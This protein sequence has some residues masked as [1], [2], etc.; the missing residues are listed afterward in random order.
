MGEVA[1]RGAAWL[2]G[3]TVVS[4]VVALVG[5]VILARLLTDDEFGLYALALTIP[6]VT[7]IIAQPGIKQVLV[8][9]QRRADL[10]ENPG[11]WMSA[12]AGMAGA[13]LTAVAAPLSAWLYGGGMMMVKVVLVIAATIFVSALATVPEARM[14]MG[15]RFKAAAILNWATVTGAMALSAAMAWGGWGALSFAVPNL[16][17]A[18]V[19]CGAM[20]WMTR[21][22]IGMTLQVRRWWYMLEDT[23]FLVGTQS[24]L[25]VSQ[26]AD[27]VV[28]GLM[29]P[30]SVVG[31]Y[32]FA[33]NLSL[34]TVQLLT[35]NLSGVLFAALNKLRDEPER[36]AAAFLRASRM[37]ALVGIPACVAQAAIAEPVTRLLFGTKWDDAIAALT[38]LS[39]GAGLGLVNAPAVSL[40][41]AQGRF[42][43]VMLMSGCCAILFAALV[44]AASSVGESAAVGVGVTIYW[45]L[46]GVVWIRLGLGQRAAWSQIALIFLL[47]LS[48]SLVAGAAGWG[49]TQL[50][51][52]TKAGLIGAC[53]S[54][55]LT[56]FLVYT[57]AIRLVSHK[58]YVEIV[59]LVER[60][61]PVRFKRGTGVSGV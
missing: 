27:V 23:L 20:W 14:Q 61:V 25:A 15:L 13:A 56:T 4:K 29:H 22:E 11:F 19:R 52:E 59:A 53:M 57:F 34:Q 55:A 2:I 10:W 48:L 54:G 50:F 16:A 38:I 30:M 17:A 5:Q 9:R 39:V 24:M 35:V 7:G 42:K 28:L 12:T 6:T 49:M 8:Q 51:D 36:Q 1:A 44:W 58:S 31:Q 3:L 37:L 41:Q 33:Y 21:P 18:I 32:S 26:R 46:T 47:P 45:G 40:L 60:F 43:T